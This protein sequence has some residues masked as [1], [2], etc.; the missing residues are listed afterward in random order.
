MMLRIANGPR[1]SV[2]GR[3]RSGLATVVLLWLGTCCSPACLSRAAAAQEQ[4]VPGA[5]QVAAA[6][7]QLG[8]LDYATRMK[9]SRLI[10]R[11]EANLATTALLQAIDSHKD[12]Y[13]RFRALV[14]LAGFNDPRIHDVMRRAVDDPNDRLREAGFAWFERNPDRQLA[15]DFVHRLGTEVAEFVRPALVRALAAL[16]AEPLVKKT[17]TAEVFRGQD[18]F[19]SAVIEAMGD[20][21]ARYALASLSE[22]ARLEGPLR[23]DAVMALGRIGDPRALETFSAL[24]RSAS[25]EDQ[26]FIAAAI[27]LTGRN[28]DAHRRFL[29]ETLTFA[30]KELGF[31]ELLRG[32][33]TGLGALAERGDEGALQALF[34][35]GVS[36][37]DPVRS[38]IAL[39]LGRVAVRD[40]GFLVT[41]L[42]Q[43]A[44]LDGTALL[45]RDA[46][47]MLE[48]DFDE[49]MFYVTARRAYWQAAPESPARRVVN[50]LMTVLEF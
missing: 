6:I 5:A 40:P 11:A 41:W 14:L 10:R 19:R 38:P 33:A 15:S 43:S 13:V 20:H 23:D 3:V 31:Q 24:Q 1:S 48:E 18:F 12:G 44:D 45:L 7:D 9:A 32:A 30:T 2:E 26:T 35:A 21:R 47:D 50:R 8:E 25:R 49:E 36:A 46:F 29:V 22:I 16:G 37:R 27:C 34:D 42:Q 39:A 4:P 28:C 17:L